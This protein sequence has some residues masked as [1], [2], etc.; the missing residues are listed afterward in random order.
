MQP[1]WAWA[2]LGLV[3]LSVELLSGTFYIL[4]FAISALCVALMLAAYPGAPFSL[5]LLLFSVLS[6]VALALW[7]RRY[8]TQGPAPVIG[9]SHDDTIGKVGVISSAV[10]PQQNGEIR[11]TV[12]VM[13]SRVWMAIADESIGLGEEAEVVAVEG[14]FLRVKRKST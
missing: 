2:I 12:P 5:Q 8:Q 6:L 11:F 13:S 9:Q 7:R 3:L 1:I 10:S 4:W 14:N